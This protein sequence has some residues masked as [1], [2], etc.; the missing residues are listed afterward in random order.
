[1]IESAEDWYRCEAPDLLRSLARYRDRVGQGSCEIS[2][3]KG[4]FEWIQE[5]LGALQVLTI[6]APTGRHSKTRS[7]FRRDSRDL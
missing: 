3:L 7:G 5:S 2:S 4:A 1:M 6:R